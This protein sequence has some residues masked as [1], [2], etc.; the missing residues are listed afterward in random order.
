MKLD[1]GQK[2][3]SFTTW[4]FNRK[5]RYV[6]TN[7][8]LAMQISNKCMQRFYLYALCDV[9]LMHSEITKTATGL[10]AVRSRAGLPAVGYSLEAIKEE[11]LHNLLLKVF[12]GL[13]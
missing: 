8:Q 4:F 5:Q 10:T 9:L 13:I 12:I 11:R 6:C 1:I 2:I 3:H 7:V